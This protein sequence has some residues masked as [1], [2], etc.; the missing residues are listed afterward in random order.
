MPFLQCIC[1]RQS[2]FVN[3][4]WNYVKTLRLSVRPAH[5]SDF[6]GRGDSGAGLVF[7]GTHEEVRELVC[8]S[9]IR[10]K[11][12]QPCTGRRPEI[13]EHAP[14]NEAL[15]SRKHADSECM[16]GSAQKHDQGCF[17]A[18]LFWQ[19]SLYQVVRKRLRYLNAYH[20]EVSLVWCNTVQS[21]WH[22]SDSMMSFAFLSQHYDMRFSSAWKQE[23]ADPGNVHDC[24]C[25][26]CIRMEHIV[27]C[28]GFKV[29]HKHFLVRRNPLQWLTL[30]LEHMLLTGVFSCRLSLVVMPTCFLGNP[31]KALK[32]VK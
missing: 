20:V 25:R 32:L 4:M 13:R 7:A 27:L 21:V 22:Y 9:P 31:P 11:T 8:T 6:L 5:K 18:F 1:C 2:V 14:L 17:S 15:P 12:N 10:G 30:R 24:V 16:L 19:Q 23:S 28:Y 29:Q 26:S 3:E